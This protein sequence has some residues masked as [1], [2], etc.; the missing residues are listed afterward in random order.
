MPRYD[1]TNPLR[2]KLKAG[3]TTHGLWVTLESATVTEICV[4]TG[5]DWV[6]ID[7]EHGCLDFKDVLDHL[8][9]ARGSDMAVLVRVPINSVDTIKKA[10]D[11]GSQGVLLPLISDAEELNAA[12]RHARYPKRGE[13]GIGGERAAHWGLA[14][15]AYVQAADTETMVIPLI[16][17]VSASRNINE[18]LGVEG[19]EAIFFGPAD[20]SQ[21]YGHQA[22][23]EGP[24]VADDII[25]MTDL[26]IA[27]GIIPGIIGRGFDDISRR[28]EQGFR[29]I[30]LG[31]DVGAMMKQIR[32]YMKRLKG[33]S[34]ESAWF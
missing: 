9:A 33:H 29:M 1:F 7:M 28:T 23:W 2:K 10:L 4:E 3:E 6:C 24:G 31:S 18:I 16:E 19:L 8:R 25:R 27:K 15:E 11:L 32:E 34:L 14:L 20:L 26:A 13:R 30:G 21:S 17:T 22:I 12:F 5:F